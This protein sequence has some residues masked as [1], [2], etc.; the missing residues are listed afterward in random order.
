[1]TEISQEIK[2]DMKLAAMVPSQFEFDALEKAKIAR[3]RTDQSAVAQSKA[4]EYVEFQQKVFQLQNPKNTRQPW[5]LMT[6]NPRE[7]T[8]Y[9]LFD[10]KIEYMVEEWFTWSVRVY[11]LSKTGRLHCH[12]LGLIQESKQNAN[13]CRIKAPF[14]SPTMCEN[15]KH[16]DIRYVPKAEL[17]RTYSY[18]TK[19]VV[20]NS[21]QEAH[22]KTLQWRAEN[23]IPETIQR[24]DI[25]T[26]LSPQPTGLIKLN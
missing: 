19:A 10:D 12:L 26:C 24:G 6:I 7:G 1:M 11:E 9:D 8:D 3:Y 16:I 13:F 18:I 20:G 15:V 2:N 25:P 23:S 14:I 4:G 22:V 5:C 17:F 21:K